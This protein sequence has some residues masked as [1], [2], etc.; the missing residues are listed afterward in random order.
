MSNIQISRRKFLGVLGIGAVAVALPGC[1]T[2]K[3]SDQA[4]QKKL[5]A[6]LRAEKK[7]KEKKIDCGDN[8]FSPKEAS[9]EAGTIVIW[10]N[11]GR[12]IHDVMDDMGSDHSDNKEATEH[13]DF[14]SDTLRRGDIHVVLF[15]TPGEYF[16]HCHFHGGPKRGQ[17]GSITVK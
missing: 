3:T 2:T 15:D 10:T 16:Y 7:Y 8:Y 11:I 14:T 5:L 13:K 4:A 9:V 1:T 12:N 6:D 17:W